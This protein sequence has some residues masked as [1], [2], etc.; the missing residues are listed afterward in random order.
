MD[1]YS[2]PNMDM[3]CQKKMGKTSKIYAK[4]CK[5]CKQEIYVHIQAVALLC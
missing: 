5:I 3:S 1:I 4:I 2:N